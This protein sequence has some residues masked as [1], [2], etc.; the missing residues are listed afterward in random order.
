MLLLWGAIKT[1][2]DCCSYS[3]SGLS[4]LLPLV[5]RVLSVVV[6]LNETILTAAA[7]IF[8]KNLYF[9]L[10]VLLLRIFPHLRHIC[11]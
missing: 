9:P 2:I 10:I 5:E 4:S 11:S 6:R 1:V 3:C 7:T 8:G